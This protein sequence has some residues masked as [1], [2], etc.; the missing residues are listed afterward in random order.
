MKIG[1]STKM[2]LLTV[3]LVIL[4]SGIVEFLVYRENNRLL[5][6]QEFENLSHEIRHQSF[7]IHATM[8]T[9][10][11]DV[12]FLSRLPSIQGIIRTQE[13]KDSLDGVTFKRWHKR[14]ESIFTQFLEK[15]PGYFQVRLIG[16]AENGL[17]LL[18]VQQNTQKTLRPKEGDPQQ[19]GEYDYFKEAI[20]YRT[21][22]IYLSSISLNRVQGKIAEPR[23][24]VL[25]AAAPV[26]TST[27]QLFGIVVI[28]LSLNSMFQGLKNAAPAQ[29][30]LYV[31]NN[32]GDF[33]VHPDTDKTFA[34][35]FGTRQRIQNEYPFLKQVF[36]V[37]RANWKKRGKPLSFQNQTALINFIEVH[38]NPI[39]KEQFL[40]LALSTPIDLA[41]AGANASQKKSLFVSLWVIAGSG[42][43][44][45]LFTRILVGPLR[46]I[47]ESAKA[48]GR[49]QAQVPLPLSSGDETGILARTL[50][51]MMEQIAAR[52]L[53]LLR[54][55][56]RTQAIVDHTADG[57]I[58]INKRSQIQSYNATCEAIFG[59]KAGE[60]IG[61]NISMLMPDSERKAHD[62]YMGIYNKTGNKHILGNVREVT[63]RRKN[64]ETFPLRLAVNQFDI[65]NE[66]LF[67]G[68]M[69]DISEEKAA[70]KELLR[71]RDHLEE[72][73]AEQTADLRL[74]KTK[75]EKADKAKS[76]FLAN[77]SHELRTPMHSIIGFSELGLSILEKTAQTE[78]KAE[79]QDHLKEILDSAN[80]LMALLNNLLDLSKLEANAMHF[81]F[82]ENNLLT[83]V[84]DVVKS[85]RAQSDAKQIDITL[86]TTDGPVLAEFDR[87]KIYQV[88]L[89]F[90]SNALK[91]S[92]EK[93]KIVIDLE[94]A[95]LPVGQRKTDQ[96]CRDAITLSVSD[97][98][99]GIPEDELEAVFD[100]FIQSSKTKDGSGGTGLG[101]AICNE[102]IT[103]H[104]GK[105]QAKNKPSLGA[106]FSFTIPKQQLPNK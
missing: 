40:G 10:R 12:S 82:E 104:A 95:S 70:Q 15:K 98:G 14:L 94:P 69:Q 93:K 48:F 86:T 100:K 60:T 83:L 78:K 58:T 54:S 22:G 79:L 41:M 37:E 42:L 24:P 26:F 32:Q 53:A 2:T 50:N 38:Y 3:V 101:L 92:A 72:L 96:K 51:T 30:T 18:R 25:R 46:Q 45:F 27:K 16:V 77:M 73:V 52:R 44:A 4:S 11:Q 17:E 89:N 55:E 39:E 91:F 21:D 81:Q 68:I 64:G 8:G 88:L 9:L 6:R 65:E 49:G 19:I 74:A 62:H 1:L 103:A 85:L 105:I 7:K 71:H 63:G 102:I 61:Q 43:L 84:E 56:K 31:T 28:D 29:S 57:I 36:G 99:P 33:L 87:A 80:R 47:T 13:G 20:H 106:T 76:E 23:N 67:V 34:F 90:L 5:L 35:D 75:A 59:Y 66:Q 97:E